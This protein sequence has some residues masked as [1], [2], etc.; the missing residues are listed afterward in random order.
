MQQCGPELVRCL[1]LDCNPPWGASAAGAMTGARGPAGMDLR[2]RQRERQ[3]SRDV[4]SEG[5][6]VM[7]RAP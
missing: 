6:E 7:T 2:E 3:V 1:A 4:R 5:G